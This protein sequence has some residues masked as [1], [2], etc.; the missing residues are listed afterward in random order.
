MTND[1]GEI[2]GKKKR[3]DFS[4]YTWGYR[5]IRQNEYL[6]EQENPSILD[7]RFEVCLDW[8]IKNACFYK[9][10]FYVM[11]I[12][13]GICPIISV[14]LNNMMFS[15]INANCIQW[16]AFILSIAAGG[17]VTIL[18]MSRAQDKWTRYRISAEFLKRMRTE[19]LC[20]KEAGAGKDLDRKY[21]KIIEDFM[22]DENDQWRMKNL[23]MS[24]SGKTGKDKIDG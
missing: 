7:K 10:L 5:E 17:S 8:Y 14:G 22:A 24:H 18:S 1:N 21:L 2:N 15:D 16:R 12:L 23:D 9:T 13:S 3:K 6:F 11:T 4:L 19:Y 20:E